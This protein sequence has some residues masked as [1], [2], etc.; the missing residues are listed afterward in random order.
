[1]RLERA[2]HRRGRRAWEA[3]RRPAGARRVGAR[4]AADRAYASARR[5]VWFALDR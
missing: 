5:V 2:R 1:M 3:A 4:R